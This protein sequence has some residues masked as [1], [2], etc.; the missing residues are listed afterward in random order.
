MCPRDV[1][2]WAT[3]GWARSK[4][5]KS[6]RERHA[7]FRTVHMFSVLTEDTEVGGHCVG[8]WLVP[9]FTTR[10]ITLLGINHSV[11]L[12]PTTVTQTIQSTFQ[13]THCCLISVCQCMYTIFMQMSVSVCVYSTEVHYVL[14]LML[15]TLLLFYRIPVQPQTTCITP[16]SFVCCNFLQN[17]IC[18]CPR[19]FTPRF[20]CCGSFPTQMLVVF[21]PCLSLAGL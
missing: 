16:L 4:V 19:S 21:S 13:L 11:S 5:R 8:V 9:M 6:V 18:R 7:G 15:L 10:N 1:E 17:A 2:V 3:T 14:V 20:L 12:A